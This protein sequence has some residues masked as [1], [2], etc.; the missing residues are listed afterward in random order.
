MPPHKKT[1]FRDLGI[2]FLGAALLV[3][4]GRDLRPA[5]SRGFCAVMNTLVG[6]VTF[7]SGGHAEFRPQTTAAAATVSLAGLIPGQSETWDAE[8]RLTD[9]TS[10]ASTRFLL[11]ARGLGFIPLVLLFAVVFLMPLERRRAA[12]A[13]ALAGAGLVAIVVGW[14]SLVLI[15]RFSDPATMAVYQLQPMLKS[16]LDSAVATLV[17]PPAARFIAPLGLGLSIV[18]WQMSRQKKLARRHWQNQFD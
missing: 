13:G 12:L 5:F 16:I 11:N 15:S 4:P 8:V 7:G 6:H 10:H 9:D 14:T 18:A 3:L 1:L 2:L 17:N